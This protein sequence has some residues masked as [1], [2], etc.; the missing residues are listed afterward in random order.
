MK[1]SSLEEKIKRRLKR[2]RYELVMSFIL[3]GIGCILAILGILLYF[4]VGELGA[5]GSFDFTLLYTLSRILGIVFSLTGVIVAGFSL[6]RIS[7][8]KFIHKMIKKENAKG[9]Q[10]KGIYP[11]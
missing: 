8:I 1:K 11:N 4:W 3:F 10:H 9:I 5:F 2:H 6:D 7:L